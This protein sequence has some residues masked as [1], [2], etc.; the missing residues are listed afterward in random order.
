MLARTGQQK[1]SITAGRDV[2]GT[3]TLEDG[4]VVSY[5]AKHR[6][7]IQ[8][9]NILLGIYPKELKTYIATKTCL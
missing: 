9:S 3:A 7:T 8:S 1:L 5:K 2:N 6:L 4:L